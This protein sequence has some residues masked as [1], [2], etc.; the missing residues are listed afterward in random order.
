MIARC[1]LVLEYF[2]WRLNGVIVA[3][4]SATVT[5]I[6]K[7]FRVK[8]EAFPLDAIVGQPTFNSIRHLVD[9][10]AAFTSHFATTE[11]GGQA[12]FP[13]ARAQRDQNSSRR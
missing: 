7:M 11:W 9:Q 8:M 13:P 10:L 3:A 4:I 1:L 12:R 6:T 5:T 2:S